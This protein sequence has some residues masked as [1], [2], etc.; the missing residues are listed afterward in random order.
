M[1]RW[2]MTAIPEEATPPQALLSLNLSAL[3]VRRVTSGSMTSS[4]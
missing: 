1:A 2:R 3:S 4:I